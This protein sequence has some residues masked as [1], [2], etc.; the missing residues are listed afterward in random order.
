MSFL[1]SP[2]SQHYL[3]RNVPFIAGDDIHF[4]IHYW[5]TTFSHFVHP[6]HKHSFFEVCYVVQG[7]G[8]YLEAGMSYSL[9]PGSIF[10]SRPERLH[11][12]QYGRD[13]IMLFVGFDVDKK[14]C[15]ANSLMI[16]DILKN[17]G[18]VLVHAN[19]ASY[20]AYVWKALWEQASDP[21]LHFNSIL[22]QLSLAL[23]C[24]FHQSFTIR[25]KSRAPLRDREFSNCLIDQAKQFIQDNLSQDISVE[26][27]ANYLYI[28]R[29]HL[30]RL[31]MEEGISFTSYLL[32]KRIERACE[33]LHNKHILIK[34][35]LESTGF[36][37]V[38]YF[39]RIFT[40]E[41]GITP[42]RYRDRVT[43]TYSR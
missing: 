2:E 34:D 18:H 42:A 1:P 8:V 17:T 7:R 22:N 10:M 14:N 24:S 19:S 37:S 28:S 33:L 6:M 40:R 23:L 3:N 38:H 39:T 30:T 31:F 11:Q 41:V 20:T 32:E 5:G 25:Q 26:D 12:I 16:Y 35:I 4:K 13:M 21:P 15:T 36:H 29:R 43:N 9:E 27:I